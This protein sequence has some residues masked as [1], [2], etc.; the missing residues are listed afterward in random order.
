M[1][2]LP[3]RRVFLERAARVHNLSGGDNSCRFVV[4]YFASGE[5]MFVHDA[6]LGCLSGLQPV[7]LFLRSWPCGTGNDHCRALGRAY[8]TRDT[9]I[10]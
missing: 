7:Q 9:P 2:Q 10:V 8:A 1:K 6:S 4:A 3:R 5:G